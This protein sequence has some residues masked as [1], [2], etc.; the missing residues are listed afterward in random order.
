MIY[1]YIGSILHHTMDSIKEDPKEF[2]KWANKAFQDGY[3][4]YAEEGVAVGLDYYPCVSNHRKDHVLKFCT[5]LSERLD[6]NP[7]LT[8]SVCVITLPSERKKDDV[9]D[10]L[11]FY[12]NK[13]IY[14]SSV[15]DTHFVLISELKGYTQSKYGLVLE[16][17]LKNAIPAPE[18][19]HVRENLYSTLERFLAGPI[20]REIL[21][22]PSKLC[23][24]V[25]H[26][27]G[28]DDPTYSY[29]IIKETEVMS[30]FRFVDVIQMKKNL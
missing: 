12:D 26:R 15:E 11:L 2:V 30:K 23:H 24:K 9:E 22:C 25:E 27:R 18:P 7:E 14:L 10:N 5:E 28:F 4:S 6:R 1:K 19:Y 3:W 21:V 8:D 16:D 13:M 29:E 17:Y 20:N